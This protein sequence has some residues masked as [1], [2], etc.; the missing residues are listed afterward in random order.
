MDGISAKARMRRVM[1]ARGSGSIEWRRERRA[2]LQS[3]S[4]TL[5]ELSSFLDGDPDYFALYVDGS[6]SKD[7]ADLTWI[8]K[9]RSK[10]VLHWVSKTFERVHG[11][12]VVQFRDYILATAEREPKFKNMYHSM[13]ERV[14]DHKQD[15]G[16]RINMYPDNDESYQADTWDFAIEVNIGGTV[17][18]SC[19][20][21][22]ILVDKMHP[23]QRELT[24]LNTMMRFQPVAVIPVPADSSSNSNVHV[25]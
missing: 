4:W 7:E 17:R 6:A 10:Y 18:L 13:I 1:D 23:A 24:Y 16:T 3:K 22:S 21:E 14:M 19:M 8:E 15:Y 12:D 9:M 2:I 5:V 25:G 11:K 20:Q